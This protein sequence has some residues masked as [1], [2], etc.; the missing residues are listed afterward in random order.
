M[1]HSV[2][3]RK[4]PM[5][6]ADICRLAVRHDSVRYF[7]MTAGS[8]IERKKEFY[9]HMEV[10]KAIRDV[11]PWNGEIRGNVSLMPPDDIRMLA[12]LSE[13]GVTNPS[14][15]LEVWPQKAFEYFCPGKSK[16]VGFQHILKSYEFL[17]GLYGPGKLW[18]NFVAGLVPLKDIMAGFRE[19][20]IR[21]V[22]PGA[23][24][25]H[26]EV[27]SVL[28]DTIPSPDENY[29]RELYLYASELYHQYDYRPF[30][31][32]SVLRNSLANEAYMGWL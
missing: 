4:S 14:F 22:V 13:V 15:N 2:E 29:I 16:Y 30:F 3:I 25:Y 9:R 21:G 12:G 20:A 28:G 19:M 32:E 6:L 1:Y 5:D 26:P 27:G 17:V 10:L 8:T 11:L 31:D 18:C 24:V 23:N 7:L